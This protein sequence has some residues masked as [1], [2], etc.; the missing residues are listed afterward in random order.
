VQRKVEEMMSLLNFYTM[1]HSYTYGKW[2]A[3]ALQVSVSMGRGRH[4]AHELAKLVQQFIQD[5][6]FLPTNLY[7][8]W[9]QSMLVDQD[10]ANDIN[11]YLQEIGKDITAIKLVHFLAR[12]EVKQK[13]GI[14]KKISERTAHR[15]LNALG[16]QYRTPIKGQYADGHEH[17]DVVWYRD[18][19]FLPNWK[20]LE[21]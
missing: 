11:L 15:Y 6:T 21:S 17:K 12:P 8:D 13:H 7:G 3:S 18:H 14:T 16:Y 10:L 5:R 20:A 19:K 4:C 1:R 2:G 9:N